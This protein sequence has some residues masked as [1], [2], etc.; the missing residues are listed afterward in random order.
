[1]GIGGGA[2][3][4]QGEAHQP[5]VWPPRP[6]LQ[7]ETEE[8]GPSHRGSL[9]LSLSLSLF[10]SFFLDACVWVFSSFA[11]SLLCPCSLVPSVVSVEIEMLYKIYMLSDLYL[12][13]WLYLRVYSKSWFM[14]AVCFS[15]TTSSKRPS[16]STPV[17]CSPRVT[18]SRW[19][20]LRWT[21]VTR[22]SPI[23]LLCAPSQEPWLGSRKKSVP[24]TWES[25]FWVRLCCIPRS[26]ALMS[27][28]QQ[29]SYRCIQYIISPHTSHV[30]TVCYTWADLC[31]W[32]CQGSQVTH[33]N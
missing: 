22:S 16:P 17:S 27:K 8:A 10:L 32:S 26:D 20:R 1:M 5:R 24:W 6:G 11:L 18:R 19:S 13:M 7:R 23:P 30:T 29:S 2:H 3:R 12:N 14:Y 9:S 25:E 28:R 33:Y 31:D 15:I 21:I 4:H